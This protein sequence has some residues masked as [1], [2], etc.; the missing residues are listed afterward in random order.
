MEKYNQTIIDILNKKMEFDNSN[1][2]KK[3]ELIKSLKNINNFIHDSNV[4]LKKAFLFKRQKDFDKLITN[5]NELSKSTLSGEL[6][7]LLSTYNKLSNDTLLHFQSQYIEKENELINIVNLLKKEENDISKNKSSLDSSWKNDYDA[8]V[9]NYRTI[10]EKRN[11]IIADWKIKEK[12]KHQYYKDQKIEV[13]HIIRQSKETKKEFKNAIVN[14][15]DKFSKQEIDSKDNWFE[16]VKQWNYIR[17]IRKSLNPKWK[18]QKIINYQYRSTMN[19][20]RAVIGLHNFPHPMFSWVWYI[21]ILQIITR[22]KVYDALT[23]VGLKHEHAY[24]Y[25]HEFSGGQRQRIVIARALITKPKLI[26]AD[27]PIS[28]L[29]VS[30]QSQVINIM[31]KLAKEHGVTFLFIAH[32]L[33]MVSY[34]CNKVII[35]HNGKIVEKGDAVSVFKNPIHPYTKTLFNA[36]PELSKIHVDLASFDEEMNYDKNYGP[37]NKPQFEMVNGKENHQ[38][39]ATK[40]QIKEWIKK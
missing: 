5:S 13:N 4:E 2:N 15:L 34:A 30:I 36:V 19:G 40:D 8:A 10:V 6:K 16:K 17:V 25:P 31:K 12:N 22:N 35:M 39:F 11:K 33:S 3:I 18:S 29:D 24:R 37:L 27:E 26:I 21:W 23:S 14:F 38:V 1:M 20:Y 7:E 9:K 28:A 32:D